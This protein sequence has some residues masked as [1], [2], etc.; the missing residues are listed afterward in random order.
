[1]KKIYIYEGRIVKSSLPGVCCSHFV[2]IDHSWTFRILT[3]SRY[4]HVVI[5]FVSGDFV[6]RERADLCLGCM[7]SEM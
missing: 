2:L 3:C 6:S 5:H 4:H 7:G 1:M